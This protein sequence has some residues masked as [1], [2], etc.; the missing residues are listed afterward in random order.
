D[1]KFYTIPREVLEKKAV[2]QGDI[3]FFE[4]AALFVDTRVS[5]RT[6]TLELTNFVPPL[7]Y[8]PQEIRSKIIAWESW[9]DYWAV[10]FDFKGDTFH[11]EWQS[12]RTKANKAIATKT[13]NTYD[14]PGTYCVNVKVIDIL[15][16]DTTR[17]LQVE[18]A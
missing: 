7:D 11:N 2:E 15:G 9:I 5:G 17:T 8:V 12:Y 6:L 14:S 3:Q 1:L 18:I 16:N 10:D 13:T 4:L